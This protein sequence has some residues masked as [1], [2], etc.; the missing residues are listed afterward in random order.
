MKKVKFFI[1]N[2]FSIEKEI[3][4]F[5]NFNKQISLLDIKLTR[6]ATQLIAL[7]IYDKF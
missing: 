5:F 2:V 4:D 3:N 7:V 6:N 1:G